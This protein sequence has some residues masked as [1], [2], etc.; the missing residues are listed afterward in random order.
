MKFLLIVIYRYGPAY[1]HQLTAFPDTRAIFNADNYAYFAGTVF[2][3]NKC[4]GMVLPACTDPLL[5]ADVC[6]PTLQGDFLHDLP[7]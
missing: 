5:G 2:W 4:Q 3:R 1:A 6:A 7:T